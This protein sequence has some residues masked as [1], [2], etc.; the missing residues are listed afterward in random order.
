M[1]KK[2]LWTFGDSFSEGLIKLP[3]ENSVEDRDRIC[4]PTQIVKRSKHFDLCNNLSQRGA[5]NEIIFYRVQKLLDVFTS[6]DFVLIVLSHSARTA[7]YNYTMDEYVRV[8]DEFEHTINKRQPIWQTDMMLFWI[9]NQLKNRGIRYM[10]VSGFEVYSVYSKISY[11]QL[12]DLRFINP[13]FTNNTL[14]DILLGD[15]CTQ[16]SEKMNAFVMDPRDNRTAPR[17]WDYPDNKYIAEC[18]HPSEEGHILIADKLIECLQ[19]Y[20]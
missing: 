1:K 18:N 7:K 5:S 20:L 4:F 3:S 10:I 19:E 6:N 11:S 8:T 17:I 16:K 15:F 9:A 14:F 12:R 13:E 2:R